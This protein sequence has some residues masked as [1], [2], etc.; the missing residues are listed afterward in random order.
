MMF[1]VHTETSNSLQ[2]YLVPDSFSGLA[3]I[4]VIC[5]GYTVYQ[6]PCDEVVPHLVRMGR[7]ETGMT[8]FTLDRARVP[9]LAHVRD[10]WIHDAETGFL[11]YRRNLPDTYLQKRFF[12]M[13]TTLA[14]ASP[15][16]QSLLPYFAYGLSDVQVYGHETISQLFNLPQYP[17]MFFEGRVYIS[18]HQK[19]LNDQFFSA[20]SVVDPFVALAFSIDVLGHDD[21]TVLSQLEER[22]YASLVPLAGYFDGIEIDRPEAVRHHMKI[23]PQDILMGLESP[24]V[25]LLTGHTPGVGGARSAI[26]NAL[27]VLSMF[28]LVMFGHDAARGHRRLAQALG[29]NEA[30]LPQV[31]IPT[32]VQE[33]ADA[34]RDLPVLEAAL[35]ND[36]IVYHCLTQAVDAVHQTAT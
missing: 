10:L 2:G 32:H 5:D 27:N 9:D 3:R 6:G 34:L 26:P 36:L 19:Y 31:T 4:R 35:E 22:E 28:D 13:E 14:T 17:S 33:M 16:A 11:I 29:V 21:Q 8:S 20:I 24:L 1:S 18:A 25:G 30:I 7:H 23:A 12:R 15:Y